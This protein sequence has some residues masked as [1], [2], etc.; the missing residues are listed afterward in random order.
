MKLIIQGQ[1]FILGD[2]Y[3]HSFMWK[4]YCRQSINVGPLKELIK[5][6]KLIVNNDIKFFICLSSAKIL[7]IDLMVI[8]P[9]LGSLYSL[10]ILEKNYYSSDYKLILIELKNIKT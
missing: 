2:I 7:I 9:D 1:V 10:K 5:S 3:A 4:V 8:N 6:Y